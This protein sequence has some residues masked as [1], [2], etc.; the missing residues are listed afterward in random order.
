MNRRIAAFA[1]ASVAI[2]G[3]TACSGGAAED[4]A[5]DSADSADSAPAE[6]TTTDQSV[7]E[8]CGIVI[9]QLTEASSAMSEIDMTAAEVD[10]QATVDQFN[11]FVGTLGETVDS[12]SNAEVKE[13]TAAVYEDFTALGDLLTQ[14]V[15]EQDMSAAGEL[16]AITGDVT[17]SATALQELCS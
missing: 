17:A 6:E 15:V 1:I 2:L 4:T 7:E 16:S 9:P 12:V 3:L 8:A 5:N 10:P 14:V 13:A 11:S